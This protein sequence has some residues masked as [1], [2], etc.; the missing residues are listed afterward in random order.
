MVGGIADPLAAQLCAIV[1]RCHSVVVRGSVA[2]WGACP[3]LTHFVCETARRDSRNG[4]RGAA[5]VTER[6]AAAMSGGWR[7]GPAG[8][9]KARALGSIYAGLWGAAL[10]G[11]RG[12]PSRDA[13]TWKLL[14]AGSSPEQRLR[15]L[16]PAVAG[17]RRTAA[18]GAPLRLRITTCV[19]G[20][21]VYM[22]CRAPGKFL[23]A[24]G[25]GLFF[26][27]ANAWTG[28]ALG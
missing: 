9:C 20:S 6:S 21:A 7:R 5:A 1:W 26:W 17:K 24:K 23:L 14:A 12:G 4:Q 27:A 13:S 25:I 22:Q 19:R 3:A 15:L 18:S 11:V 16:A 10:R 28:R 8:D 2:G